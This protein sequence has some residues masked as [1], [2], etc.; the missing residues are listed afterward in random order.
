MK[1]G[2]TIGREYRTSFEQVKALGCATKSPKS[3]IRVLAPTTLR[4]SANSEPA[5]GYLS[6]Q[7]GIE[8]AI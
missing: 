5:G 6:R 3:A 1:T 8:G 4:Q 2:A 7:V